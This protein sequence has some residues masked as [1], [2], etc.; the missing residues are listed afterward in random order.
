MEIKISQDE[1]AI[2]KEIRLPIL[3]YSEDMEIIWANDEMSFFSGYSLEELATRKLES[4]IGET[5]KFPRD[6]IIREFFKDGNT[7]YPFKLL[8]NPLIFDDDESM[9]RGRVYKVKITDRFG[10]D[11]SAHV[12]RRENGLFVATIQ[13]HLGRIDSLTSRYSA[14]A[15]ALV[16]ADYRI[17]EYNDDFY[18]LTGQQKEKKDI[19]GHSLADFLVEQDWEYFLRQT[20]T[21]ADH[22]DDAH[23]NNRLAWKVEME[24]FHLPGSPVPADGPWRLFPDGLRHLPSHDTDFCILDGKIGHRLRDLKAEFEFK[25]GD[26]NGLGFFLCGRDRNYSG[27][28]DQGGFLAVI[29]GG[30]LQLKEN[31]DIIAAAPMPALIPEGW[32]RFLFE[33]SGGFVAVALNGIKVVESYEVP[34]ELPEMQA[35]SGFCASAETVLRNFHLFSRPTAV[36]SEL[37]PP[38]LFD[39]RFKM[40]PAQIFQVKIVK[41]HY[42]LHILNG[43][44]FTDVTLLREKEA[45]LTKSEQMREA[46]SREN[47]MLRGNLFAGKQWV[48]IG[49][50]LMERI[51]KTVKEVAPTQSNVL[52]LGET[53]TGKEVL[54]Q[55]VHSLSLRADGP[56]IK[57]DCAALPEA[58][59]E[60]E[61]FGHEK[62]A[63]TGAVSRRVGRF[64]LASG[65]TIFL[66]EIGNLSPATQAKLLRVIQDKAFERLG[67]TQTVKSDF[68]LICATNADL[69]QLIQA[70]AFRQDLYYRINVVTLTLPP[71]RERKE[72]I[73]LLAQ[74]FLE[75]LAVINK[76]KFKPLGRE[77]LDL[78]TQ[79]G[80]PGNIRELRNVIETAVVLSDKTEFGPA[81]FT[82]L[83][84]REEDDSRTE[85]NPGR[86]LFSKREI[87]LGLRKSKGNVLKAA[88]ALNIKVSRLY[89]LL[90]QLNINPDDFRRLKKQESRIEEA[91]LKHLEG[92][93]PQ[94][95]S[96]I[97]EKVSV[98][99]AMLN[100]VLKSLLRR[101]FIRKK[102]TGEKLFYEIMKG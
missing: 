79:A 58:L 42:G 96:Q 89:Y 45:A 5:Y 57:V 80:W 17:E 55:M 83:A 63:F 100:I 29:H 60:S 36:R 87:C 98:S 95:M 11:C 31:S 84:R 8:V 53:G 19:K 69:P 15:F 78:L 1:R 27:T 62:G 86:S 91:V 75:D 74:K 92:K 41:R 67:G 93:G 61:L 94:T 49:N 48:M 77:V 16:D 33:K 12:R 30:F 71:L 14:I 43:A 99:A 26:P 10:I 20:K 35:F 23:A 73:P 46:L 81:D 50:P 76:K 68:R 90:S 65:G 72:D 2:Y 9:L 39:V 102:E 82:N 51:Y 24:D 21:W 70:G 28:P 97:R 38:A 88:E 3:F 54:A 18:F 59:L 25:T 52:L 85:G 4:L 22:L 101:R 34:A 32:N 7:I 64:E 6:T 66:D 37:S 44:V 47:V 40:N 56:F 13:P